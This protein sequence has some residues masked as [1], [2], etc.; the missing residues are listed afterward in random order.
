MLGNLMKEIDFVIQQMDSLDERDGRRRLIHD[1]F[2]HAAMQLP[3]LWESNEDVLNYLIHP[4]SIHLK[5]AIKA[6]KNLTYLTIDRNDSPQNYAEGRARSRDSRTDAGSAPRSA[7]NVPS[8]DTMEQVLVHLSRDW[9]RR[10]EKV[11]KNLY[12]DGFLSTLST[13]IDDPVGRRVLVPGA[14]LGRLAAELAV[15]GFRYES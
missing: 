13:L 6:P 14:G 3:N 7:V 4:Q 11:R 1:K 12:D 8:Y 15:K 9:S 5:Y 2:R 10:G